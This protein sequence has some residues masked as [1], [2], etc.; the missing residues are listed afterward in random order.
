MY[1]E[2]IPNDVCNHIFSY[3]HIEELFLFSQVTKDSKIKVQEYY[4]NQD[5]KKLIKQRFKDRK[6][7]K[8]L[9]F[10]HYILKVPDKF[11]SCS[12]GMARVFC[13]IDDQ[14]HNTSFTLDVLKWKESLKDLQHEEW[15]Y[16]HSKFYKYC[17]DEIKHYY[18]NIY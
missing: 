10:Y 14:F 3:C 18:Y 16:N 8:Q 9:F 7:Q 13:Y 5:V 17:L 11:L 4:I 12:I 6:K 1:I 15:T 2:D